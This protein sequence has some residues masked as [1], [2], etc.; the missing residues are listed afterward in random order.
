MVRRSADARSRCTT[1]T[2]DRKT[3]I[4]SF[5][6][7]LRRSEDPFW[8]RLRDLLRER[9]LDPQEL[10]LAVSSEEGDG[11]EFGIVVSKRPCV[12]QFV[13]EYRDKDVSEGTFYEW[14]DLT[15]GFRDTPYRQDVVEAFRPLDE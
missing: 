6:D 1:I 11:L 10:I 13:F 5:T 2:R 12:C 7:L 3:E 9:G 8:A 4:E 15:N 14:N